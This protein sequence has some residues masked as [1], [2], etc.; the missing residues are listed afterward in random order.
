MRGLNNGNGNPRQEMGTIA[1]EAQWWAILG[2]K[3]GASALYRWCSRENAINVQLRSLRDSDALPVKSFV[4]I[5]RVS[6]LQELQSHLSQQAQEVWK[7]NNRQ[8]AILMTIVT[9]HG[10]ACYVF[11]CFATKPSLNKNKAISDGGITVDFWIIKVHTS[12]WSLN[13]WGSSNSWVSSNSWDHQI[14]GDHRVPL[15]H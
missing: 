14:V 9:K 11:D 6:F 13:S 5:S 1:A 7:L 4:I 12:N 10:T 15:D 8:Y 3:S 2:E